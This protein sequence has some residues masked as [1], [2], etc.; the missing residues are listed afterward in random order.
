MSIKNI[1]L[2]K[3]IFSTAAS[4]AVLSTSIIPASLAIASPVYAAPNLSITNL[5]D[6]NLADRGETL[7]YTVTVKNTG[8]VEHTNTIVGI[9]PPNLSLA[10]SGSGTYTR[11]E[12]GVTKSLPDNFVNTGGNFGKLPVGKEIIFKLK[13]K[14]AN[15]ANTDD[16]IWLVAGVHSDQVGTDVVAKAWTRV[17]LK[18]PGICG[19]K[20]VEKDP[21]TV[22]DTV[23]FTIKACNSGNV[24]LH[25]V[26]IFDRLDS[27][28][29]YVAG[30][31]VLT[32]DNE[33]I[34][35]DD[36][37]RTL[38][39][40]NIGPLNPG[41]EAFLKF[42][43]K[44][45]DKAKDG[46]EIQ[47]VAQLKSNETPNWLQ[48]AVLFKVEGKGAPERG[49][50][51]IFKFE[52]TN[53]DA[54]FNSGERGLPGFKF[55]IVGDGIDKV[56]TTEGDGVVIVRD[57][58]PGTYTITETVPSG[59]IITTDNNIKVTVKGGDLTE[60]RFGNKQVGKV[61]GKIKELPNT[62]PGLILALV[63]GSVPAGIY[64]R[65]LKTKI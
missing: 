41:Q 52:D 59:W 37:W 11:T 14:V 49:H 7:S 56:V 25:D 30:S 27:R 62:G 32:V 43:V 34:K 58:E 29:D 48:C 42:K 13:T 53:G 18:N 22:G 10:V 65:R 61:L 3:K 21:V 26:L 9:N 4:V 15:N 6:K 23:A 44:I 35:I 47:N 17:I 24:V 55:R 45:N 38:Q 54:V 8:T 51:K 5:V 63:A 39:H 46:D 33:V 20:T 19:K 36:G 12:T 16:I 57:L 28:L 40:V 60:V 1:N 2:I 64:L 50:L 31:T